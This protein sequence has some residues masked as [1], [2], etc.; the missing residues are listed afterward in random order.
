MRR[1]Q[2]APLSIKRLT[3]TKSSLRHSSSDCGS[4]C[5]CC[6][7]H[8]ASCCRSPREQRV[9]TIFGCV[10]R[11]MRTSLGMQTATARALRSQTIVRS[12]ISSEANQTIE[13]SH[14]TTKSRKFLHCLKVFCCCQRNSSSSSTRRNT[15]AIA[16]ACGCVWF[17]HRA[18][19]RKRMHLHRTSAASCC[20]QTCAQVGV[21]NGS[22]NWCLIDT[23]MA[24]VLSIS[25][26]ASKKFSCFRKRRRRRCVVW[27]NCVF[28]NSTLV[29]RS[30]A[31]GSL[32]QRTREAEMRACRW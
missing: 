6:Y 15:P 18:R 8:F 10:A 14:T 5:R 7:H 1:A 2:V 12:H 17:S 26:L 32:L 31:C 21:A 30:L 23:Q 29:A 3:L 4:C 19:A 11:E 27:R 28:A 25:T 22:V 16:A 24:F 9:T 13:C 20:V